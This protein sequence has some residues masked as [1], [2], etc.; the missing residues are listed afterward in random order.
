MPMF[1]LSSLWLT[2]NFLI[3]ILYMMWH[4]AVLVL[5]KCKGAKLVKAVVTGWYS[6]L[7]QWIYVPCKAEIGKVTNLNKNISVPCSCA[8]FEYDQC[9]CQQCL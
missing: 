9:P 2:L 8:M 3:P 7:K 1:T 5:L 4:N 6:N